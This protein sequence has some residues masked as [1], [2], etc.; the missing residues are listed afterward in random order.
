[1]SLHPAA[2]ADLR[3]VPMLPGSR[4]LS[5]IKVIGNMCSVSDTSSPTFGIVQTAVKQITV[6]V[7]FDITPRHTNYIHVL[8]Y[9]S[10]LH[11]IMPLA[12]DNN[13]FESQFARY[14]HK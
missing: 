12:N 7:C 3:M 11:F 1:M 10:N 9:Y 8:T 6:D 14:S 5:Q 13:V 4:M 2:P